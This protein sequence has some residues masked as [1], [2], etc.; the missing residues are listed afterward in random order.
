MARIRMRAVLVEEA[1][2]QRGAQGTVTRGAQGTTV[3][4]EAQALVQ[5]A[6]QAARRAPR[7]AAVPRARAERRSSRARLG[8]AE[9][10]RRAQACPGWPARS[11][12]AARPAVLG[13]QTPAPPVRLRRA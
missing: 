5:G 12:W 2:A 7:A 11:I 10:V 3:T 1:P 13:S 9:P 6:P 4:R 8:Q